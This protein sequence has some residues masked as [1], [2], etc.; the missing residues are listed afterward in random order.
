[1]NQLPYC[2][3]YIQALGPTF[4]AIVA[5]GI[6]GYIA[7]RQWRTAHDKLTF[8]LYEKRFEIYQAVKLFTDL[9]DMLSGQ[10]NNKEIGALYKGIRG[11][12]FLFGGKTRKLVR[13][14]TELA[15]KAYIARAKLASEI[16]KLL[17]EEQKLVN[18][19]SELSDPIEDMFRPY[20]DLSK[21]GLKSY[22]P[23]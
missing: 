7:W 3:Q 20:L 22:W 13:D 16:D 2:V 18:Y 17:P 10:V 19:L 6:A 9:A 11:A 1:M 4:V 12:E 21:T 15:M 8:D 14:I 23:S 5:A